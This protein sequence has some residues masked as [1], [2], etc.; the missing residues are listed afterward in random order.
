MSCLSV[1]CALTT[2]GGVLPE[3]AA[4]SSYTTGL[5]DTVKYS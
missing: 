5:L 4:G 3:H 2:F 1:L